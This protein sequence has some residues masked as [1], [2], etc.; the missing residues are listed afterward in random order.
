[1]AVIKRGLRPVII[2]SIESA[3]P[4]RIREAG[5]ISRCRTRRQQTGNDRPMTTRHATPGPV[6][7][8]DHVPEGPSH[9]PPPTFLSANARNRRCERPIIENYS[10]DSFH[11]IRPFCRLQPLLK[12]SVMAIGQEKHMN[13][14]V[15]YSKEES[16]GGWWDFSDS[17][18][19]A[20]ATRV[21]FQGLL[22]HKK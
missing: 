9:Q 11:V 20:Y 18:Y 7:R 5:E 8:P 22:R 16:G 14:P 3:I 6:T 12:W 13:S 4:P 19:Q 1:M 17:I 15:A 10:S 2:R 21:K